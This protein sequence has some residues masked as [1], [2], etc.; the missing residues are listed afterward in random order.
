M[1]ST[2][3]SQPKPKSINI[4]RI[5]FIAMMACVELLTALAI[6]IML[7]TF[8]AIRDKFSLGTESTATAKIVTFFFFG[9]FFQLIFG[10]LADKYGRIPVLRM[11]F[12]LY[13]GACIAGVL[14]PSMPWLLAARFVMGMGSSAMFV[15]VLACVRDRFAGNEMARTMSLILTIFLIVPV[16]APLLGAFILSVSNWQVVFITPAIFSVIIFIWS[17]RLPESVPAESRKSADLLA[18]FQSFRDVFA[19]RTFVRYTSITTILFAAFISYVGSSERIIGTLYQ[20]PQLFVYIF[21]AI[22]L[23]MSISSFINARVVSWLG[24]R[25]TMQLLLCIYVLLAALLLALTLRSATPLNIFVL[26][27]IIGLLQSVNL[28]I[29]PNSSSLALEPMGDKAGMAA[30]IYGTSYLVVGSFGGS[31]ID[32][33]L[34]HSVVPLTV[35]YCVGGVLALGI[36]FFR[37][38]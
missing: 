34:T 18:V 31:L 25:R 35:A 37:R 33:M 12:L 30:S 21:G 38:S 17:L 8:E 26:F 4:G 36:F 2:K 24:A 32:S 3:A 19:N 15:S 16:V 29:E 13:L 9:Q 11:G 23:S 5:E 1:L 7:P 14:A 20:Q 28:A 22:G 10:P 27:T 6:D